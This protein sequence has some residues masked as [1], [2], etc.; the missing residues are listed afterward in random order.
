[1]L[2]FL[3]RNREHRLH[4][5]PPTYLKL[6]GVH[7]EESFLDLLQRVHT[8]PKLIQTQFSGKDM[9]PAALPVSGTIHIPIPIPQCHQWDQDSTCFWFPS[10]V[11]ISYCLKQGWPRLS[12]RFR[13]AVPP[14]WFRNTQWPLPHPVSLRSAKRGITVSLSHKT[15]ERVLWYLKNCIRRREE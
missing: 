6:P 3:T 9:G 10:V 15:V 8:L 7:C 11:V 14:A 2:S 12:L 1:M 13:S 4:C 5:H